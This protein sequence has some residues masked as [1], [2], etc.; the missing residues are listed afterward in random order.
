MVEEAKMP[1]PAVASSRPPARTPAL[2]PELEAVLDEWFTR[3]FVG[4]RANTPTELWNQAQS[5]KLDLKQRLA[6]NIGE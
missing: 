6:A 1:G 3:H 2:K 5:A 4:A